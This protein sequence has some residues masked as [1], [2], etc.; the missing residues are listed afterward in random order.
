MEFP[1]DEKI[2]GTEG[3]WKVRTNIDFQ[4]KRRVSYAK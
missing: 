2:E 1:G 4:K 3:I